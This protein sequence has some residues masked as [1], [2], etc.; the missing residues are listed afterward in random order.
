MNIYTY[1]LTNVLQQTNVYPLHKTI[2]LIPQK[3]DD[4]KPKGASINITLMRL[5]LTLLSTLL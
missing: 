4:M 5:K 3:T 2:D 1:S